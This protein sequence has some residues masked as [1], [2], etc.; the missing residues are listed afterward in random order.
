MFPSPETST[1]QHE[2]P[3][4]TAYE[5]PVPTLAECSGSSVNAPPPCPLMLASTCGM[6]SSTPTACATRGAR[7][8]GM[9]AATGPLPPHVEHASSADS[10]SP[11]RRRARAR[12]RP[13]GRP[14]VGS[15]RGGHV[16]GYVRELGLHGGTVG[17]APVRTAR[18]CR[19]VRP[20]HASRLDP[21]R[22]RRKGRPTAAMS[23]STVARPHA[24]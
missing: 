10:A 4:P 7:A 2:R 3:D 9:H 22:A 12:A 24:A 11:R 19:P 1:D 5:N 6:R 23:V 15:H 17:R 14:A 16:P 20:R 21:G 18:A 8:E 13:G